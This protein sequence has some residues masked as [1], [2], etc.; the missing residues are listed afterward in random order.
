MMKLGISAAV[1]CLLLTIRIGADMSVD[2][3][4]Q[5]LPTLDGAPLSL[6]QFRGQKILL[7]DFASW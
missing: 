3:R 5:V 4:D 1:G 6:G 2:Y 7:M